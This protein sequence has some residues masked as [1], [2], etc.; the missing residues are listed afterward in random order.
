M[1]ST[2]EV[3]FG[4]DYCSGCG[5]LKNIV[6]VGKSG[7][8]EI[9]LCQECHALIQR[10]GERPDEG[11]LPDQIDP[12]KLG[13]FT[14]SRGTPREKFDLQVRKA[15]LTG[16]VLGVSMAAGAIVAGVQIL[17]LLFP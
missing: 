4:K 11:L 7:K 2:N 6:H 5:Y 13:V 17:R 1:I 9:K 14:D 15:F 12:G 10:G 3:K 8:K 16:L